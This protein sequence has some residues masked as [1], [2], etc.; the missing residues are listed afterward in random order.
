MFLLKGLIIYLPLNFYVCL[1]IRKLFA[2]TKYKN[3]FTFLFII[4]VLYI[5]LTEVLSH[6]L[7]PANLWAKY[8]LVPGYYSLPFLL[9]LFLLVLLSDIII[10][11]SR[12]TKIL[13]PETI[14]SHKSRIIRLSAL[15]VV[16]VIIII[17]GALNNN[18]IRISSY[19]I[20][21]PRKFSEITQLRIAFAA[22][23]HIK[24]ATNSQFLRK[25]VA[26]VNSL[27]PDILLICGDV[28]EGDRHDEDTGELEDLFRQIKTKY[29]VFA[30][31]GNHE[32]HGRGKRDFFIN[33][34]IILL[35]DKVQ[36]IDRAFYLVGRNDGRGLQ[37]KSLDELLIHIQDSLPV[38]LLDHRPIDI[39]RVSKSIVDIQLSGHTHNG[40]L[41]LI[42]F[43]VRK[44]Y[45]LS[46]GYMKK[47]HTHFFVT[48]GLQTWGPRIRTAGVSEIG[49]IN[50]FFHDSNLP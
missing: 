16:P 2:N 42:N 37:R 17:V 32:M 35:E 46:W 43:I 28:L 19:N 26:R 3:I 21:V 9:Y 31:P 6:L 48:S 7:A 20:D 5:P 4:T 12:K 23:F 34:D 40:Q 30:V 27:H 24:E 33:S 50:V 15:F 13:T 36:L 8:L 49:M 14:S 39:D 25:F 38:I 11:I 1:R 29:G 45:E 10:W 18:Y 44:L 41:F 47:N 22:D